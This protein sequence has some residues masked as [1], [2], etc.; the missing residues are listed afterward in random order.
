MRTQ[1]PLR[2]ECLDQGV[3][4]EAEILVEGGLLI[5]IPLPCLPHLEMHLGPF[6]AKIR[7]LNRMLNLW[8]FQGRNSV[9]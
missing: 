6:I 8:E 9:F 5:T 1:T 7:R 4:L 2:A 3:E